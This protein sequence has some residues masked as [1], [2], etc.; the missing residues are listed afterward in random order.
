VAR[1]TSREVAKGFRSDRLS[2]QPVTFAEIPDWLIEHRVTSA[3]FA[4]RTFRAHLAFQE[5]RFAL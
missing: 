2:F 5:C 3:G 1:P 4:N